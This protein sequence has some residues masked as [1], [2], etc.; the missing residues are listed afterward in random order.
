MRLPG[1]SGSSSAAVAATGVGEGEGVVA[2]VVAG[3]DGGVLLGAHAIVAAIS[4]A[5]TQIR[6]LIAFLETIEPTEPRS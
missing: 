6:A 4:A 3:A 5:E 2:G 1:P